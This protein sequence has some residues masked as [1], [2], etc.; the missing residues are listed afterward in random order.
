MSEYIDLNYEYCE[1]IPVGRSIITADQ[2]IIFS[3]S[4][5]I[6]AFSL[7]PYHWSFELTTQRL[8]ENDYLISYAMATCCFLH[9]KN[10]RLTMPSAQKGKIFLHVG[11]PHADGLYYNE[12]MPFVQKKY[13]DPYK[14]IYAIG[15][16]NAKGLGIEFA[17][18]QIAIFNESNK[19]CAVYVELS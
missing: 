15:D 1:G 17:K 3:P 11:L 5:S 6:C 12:F 14:N 18:G 7:Y 4:P 19:L 16:L 2:S 8:S 10:K 13:Y 9:C